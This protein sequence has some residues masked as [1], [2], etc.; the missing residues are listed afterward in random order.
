MSRINEN[1]LKMKDI[2]TIGIF[3]ALLFV[4]TMVAGAL[5]GISMVL[6]MYS[7]AVVAV[8]SAPLY[9]LIMAKVHKKGAVLLTFAIVF[10][11]VSFSYEQGTKIL[12]DVSFT[13]PQGG[14]T[15]IVGPSGGGKTTITRLISRFWDIQGGSITIGGKDVR[16]FT[17]DSLLKNMSMVFQNVYLFKDTI[18]NNIKFGCPE[19]SHEQVVEA[20]K[21]ARCHDFISLLPEGYNTMI[22]EGGSTLSGGEKQ[23][24]S[25]ARAMLKNAPIVLLDEATASVDPENEVYLQQAISTLVKDKTLIVIAHRLSTIRDAEQILVIDNGK[26]VQHGKH[27]ELV[28]QEGIYQKYWN[29]RQNAKAWKVAQ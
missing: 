13:I 22:G 1:K 19:A 12:D 7:V 15:A 10:D 23:R 3:S 29:I 16:E 14:M 11:H 28:L 5:M 2:A 25:I 8:L 26:L 9:M 6:N 4:V 24:I 18:E 17:S 20:A 21:K 27:D